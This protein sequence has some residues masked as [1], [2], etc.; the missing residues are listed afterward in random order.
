M[1]GANTQWILVIG[2]QNLESKMAS[3]RLAIVNQWAEQRLGRLWRLANRQSL[4]ENYGKS[5]SSPLD[6]GISPNLKEW[7]AEQGLG[8]LWR[9][10]NRQ[11]LL[12]NNSLSCFSPLRSKP[13]TPIQITC[14]QGVSPNLRPRPLLI[15]VES[16]WSLTAR[17]QTPESKMASF[18][19]A[20]FD[21]FLVSDIEEVST[22]CHGLHSVVCSLQ[23]Y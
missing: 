11:S 2:G 16:L 23:I 17:G 21:H 20:I 22:V 13:Q 15:Q 7:W 12:E 8:R 6:E 14:G 1:W 18:A 5:C 19:L 4:Q 3:T 9:L 10:T